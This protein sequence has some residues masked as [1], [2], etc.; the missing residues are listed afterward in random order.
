MRELLTKAAEYGLTVHG[1]HM[2]GGKV[3]RFVPGLK[4]IYFDLS[5]TL[6]E[7]RTVIAHELGHAHYGHAEDSEVNE[8]QADAYAAA[9]LVD[10]HWYAELEAINH[11]AEWIAD[12]MTVTAYCIIDFRSYCLTR[13]HGTTYS[14]ARMGVG[15]WAHRAAVV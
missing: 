11:D 4:R 10:P 14:R 13:V 9:L 5:L 12:E 1:S 2:T 15:Q 3:G 6:A 7:R 8:R